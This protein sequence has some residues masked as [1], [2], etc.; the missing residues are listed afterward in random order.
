[1]PQPSLSISLLQQPFQ[2]REAFPAPIE[3]S[4]LNVSHRG[5]LT[6]CGL[7]WLVTFTYVFKVNPYRS[8]YEYFIFNCQ[9]IFLCM[10]LSFSHS[11]THGH[12]SFS[13]LFYFGDAAHQVHTHLYA[14]T[15]VDISLHCSWLRSGF[16]KF[17][18]NGN[19]R[20]NFCV[21]FYKTLS[22]YKHVW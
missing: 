18:E 20:C 22:I 15:S 13:Y 19:T 6:L 12:L 5:N 1:M 3:L 21:N 9:I 4:S 7:L 8:K 17:T 14:S 10:A 11:L 16:K 2:P